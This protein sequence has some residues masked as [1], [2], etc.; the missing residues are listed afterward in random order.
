MVSEGNRCLQPCLS[1]STS[2]LMTVACPAVATFASIATIKV[3]T[4]GCGCA[5]A[6]RALVDVDAKL[7]LVVR[8]LVAFEA[9]ALKSAG[10]IA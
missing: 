3:M 10:H 8:P 6:L 9:I 7:R 4:G 1:S 5:G 2:T